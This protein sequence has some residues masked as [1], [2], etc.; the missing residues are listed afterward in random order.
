M[1]ILIYV[2][3]Y[4]IR[5]SF[6]SFAHL[7]EYFKPLLQ[8]NFCDARIY[9]NRESLESNKIPDTLKPKVI[10]PT[11]EEDCLFHE[12]LTDWNR[13]G[14]ANW[15]KLL[16]GKDEELV[17]AYMQILQRIR[18][19]FPFDIFI[20]WGEN[21]AVSKF[22]KKYSLTKIAMELGCSRP[23]FFNSI[24]LDTCGTNGNS[25]VSQIDIKDIGDIVNNVPMSCHEALLTYSDTIEARPY[26]QFFSPIN[27]N[28]CN[29]FSK[30]K[31][32]V[33]FP[34]QLYD[35]A[36]LLLFS[37]FK[38]IQDV[39]L[40]IVPLLVENGYT[41]II[42]HHPGVKQR[43]NA[44]IENELAQAILDPWKE[45]II[46]CDS[47]DTY[48]NATLFQLA[49]FMVTVNSSTGFEALYFD[50]LVVPLCKAV[51]APYGAFPSLEQVLKGNFDIKEY[52]YHIAILRKFFFEA[53]L[54]PF[55]MM[56]RSDMLYSR[57]CCLDALHK[58]YP[59]DIKSLLKNYYSAFAPSQ[60]DHFLA[61][62]RAGHTPPGTHDIK[63]FV[64]QKK[65]VTAVECLQPYVDEI[66]HKAK[67]D[68]FQ[69]FSTWLHQVWKDAVEKNKLLLQA[70]IFDA[71]YYLAHYPDVQNGEMEP[72]IHYLQYGIQE[73]RSPRL[74]VAPK[75]PE[76]LLSWILQAAQNT[77]TQPTSKET[78][79]WRKD[80][81]YFVN[82]LRKIQSYT[83]KVPI[84]VVA[85]MYY[86]NIVHEILD[87]LHNIPEAFDLYVTLPQWGNKVIIEE[88]KTAYPKTFFCRVPNYGR[89]IGPFLSI[90]PFLVQKK[91]ELLVKIQTKQGCYS[92]NEEFLKE[93]G[94]IW[95]RLCLNS[96]LMNKI[97][98]ATILKTFRQQPNLSMLG[99]KQCY[100]P[101]QRNP[102]SDAGILAKKIL[103]D[104]KLPDQIGFFAGSMFW[105]RPEILLPL[106][107]SNSPLLFPSAFTEG[108]G[109]N[110]N[111]T[112]HN[113]ER[114]FGALALADHG[115]VATVDST[116]SPCIIDL[117]PIPTEES[118]SDWLHNNK[119]FY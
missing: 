58:Q 59:D 28:I 19:T 43:P 69:D 105:V 63:R 65:K 18:E 32:Y 42:K 64:Q 14:I 66:V 41:V 119:K 84:A 52:M 51:Y 70:H 118:L 34:L 54:F 81:D 103:R 97:H 87:Y 15:T 72:F 8:S 46:W 112:A 96:L 20:C 33:F 89:D 47:K 62:S 90:L 55:S 83:T 36:N 16:S 110:V 71:D 78:C 4:P 86:K 26:E 74:G 76:D 29:T 9:M 40:N 113:V 77:Y 104:K 73:C 56:S 93:E 1:K 10:A 102:Y 39:V 5:N 114:L 67:K 79:V 17:D 115:Q 94:T 98:V 117:K 85:H 106:I 68:T 12:C 21:G 61:R 91:Y 99:S 111:T 27:K 109:A 116:I 80:Q 60:R 82:D 88:I 3:P 13:D 95:R 30:K 44:Y 100:L 23:P 38:N 37:N 101:L 107:A 11:P 53:Y 108:F 6:T 48:L 92:V 24:V 31:K 50:K 45:H 75:K 7:F 2:E 25:T 35:D 49:D 57:I 22:C